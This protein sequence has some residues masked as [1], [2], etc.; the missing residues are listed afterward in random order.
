[1]VCME[2]V[3]RWLV[4]GLA[5]LAL[6]LGSCSTESAD[7]TQLRIGINAW[8]GYE[9]LYLAQEKGFFR[10]NG[11]EVQLIEF[12][13]L[14]DVRR[15]FERNQI[16]GF[17]GTMV[18]LIQATYQSD[19]QPQATMV[20]DYSNGADVLLLRSALAP[21]ASLKGLRIGVEVGS[22]GS[23]LLARALDAQ[24]LSLSAVT[25]VPGDQLTMEA[26]F[27]RGSLDA[28]VT[29][30]PTSVRLQGDTGARVAFSSDRIKGEI[31]D[32]LIFDRSVI[33]QRSVAVQR[34]LR[35]F[36]QALQFHRAQ[37]TEASAIMG[38][39][40]GVSAEAFE[41]SLRSGIEL[42]PAA[43]QARYFGQASTL[44]QLFARAER[45]LRD[46]GQISEAPKPTNLIAQYR[47]SP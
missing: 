3:S 41:A 37:P 39:R 11:V 12:N 6:S 13:S 22:L 29:Y 25:I 42:V 30:P 46:T 4:A 23:Y 32:L 33:E 43:D 31:I 21:D 19:R 2:L 7:R 26:E 44:P 47:T 17:A 28:I 18:E 1:M 24:Q 36:E 15:S 38:R 10:E 5:L 35:A 16:D 27:R 14:S 34:V 9:F 8:P 45:V 20:I 40:E